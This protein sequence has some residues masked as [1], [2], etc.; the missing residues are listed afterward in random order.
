MDNH[1]D[2]GAGKK[3]MV[4]RQR[5]VVLGVWGWVIE[6]LDSFSALELTTCELLIYYEKSRR[7][8][9]FIYSE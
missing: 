5:S 7:S 2:S 1:T 9:I 6:S 8:T 4:E 3:H